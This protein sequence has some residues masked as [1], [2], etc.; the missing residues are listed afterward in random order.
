MPLNPKLLRS[1]MN[2]MADEMGFNAQTGRCTNIKKAEA[3]GLS[4]KERKQISKAFEQLNIRGRDGQYLND[5]WS[6]VSDYT[7]Q[8]LFATYHEQQDG[9]LSEKANTAFNTAKTQLASDLDELRQGPRGRLT[10]ARH[11]DLGYDSQTD[12][13]DFPDLKANTF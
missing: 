10:P 1:S 4:A 13:S 11:I 7:D 2:T 5:N 12:G 9:L 3:C 8:I 6:S